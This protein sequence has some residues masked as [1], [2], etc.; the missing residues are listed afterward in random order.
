MSQLEDFELLLA[1]PENVD[2][3][4]AWFERTFDCRTGAPASYALYNKPEYRGPKIEAK[5]QSFVLMCEDN[6]RDEAALCRALYRAAHQKLMPL[7]GRKLYWRYP[8]RIRFE[9]LSTGT[10]Y[11]R[12][13]IEG[14]PKLLRDFA[15]ALH[16]EVKS[17]RWQATI[18]TP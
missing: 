3:L 12:F 5:Y 15:G 6:K 9:G 14:L 4:I 18:G 1:G 7:K 13:T 17:D 8:E 16:A 11:A 2:D 10:L